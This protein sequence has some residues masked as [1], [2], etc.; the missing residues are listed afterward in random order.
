M[1]RLTEPEKMRAVTLLENDWS[2]QAVADE[3]NVSKS[4]IFK[5]KQ[6]WNAVGNVRYV[7]GGGRRKISTVEQDNLFLDHLRTNPFETAVTACF[8]TEF[9][10]SVRSARRRVKGSELRN[11]AAAKKVFL[12]P[13]HKEQRLNFANQFVG[14]PDDFWNNVI[15]SDEKVFQS[16]H[17]GSIRVYRPQN[18]RYEERYIKPTDRSG[19][20]SINVWAWISSLGPGVCWRIGERLTGQSYIRILDNI[21]LPSVTML[22]PQNFIFQQDNCSIHTSRIV[23]NW[24]NEHNINVLPWPSKSPD[25]NPIEN[26]W[27]MIVKN[28][29]NRPG[30]RHFRPANA[31]ELWG[32]I[33]NAW[34]NI[35]VDYTRTLVSSMRRRLQG[36]IDSNG[37]WTKY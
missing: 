14:R 6:K 11:Y 26:A 10:G 28:I 1:P 21:M 2:L 32:A 4:C 9:P 8:E 3:L 7:H 16:C 31:E 27:S 20:F 19:R 13:R 5:L 12:E 18:S 25:L 22:Y 34:D 30:N 23:T 24:I 17:D 15:F 36:V 29:Y 33:E 35:N 37:A